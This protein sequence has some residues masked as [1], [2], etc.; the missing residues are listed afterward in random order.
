MTAEL[1]SRGADPLKA[2]EECDADLSLLHKVVAMKGDSD[3]IW[4]MKQLLQRGTF[5]DKQD[6]MN[7]KT[8]LMTCCADG[9]TNHEAMVI[10]L[11]HGADVSLVYD[12]VCHSQ[13]SSLVQ[14][15]TMCS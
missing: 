7:G 8:P 9:H 5:I 3:C 12:E 13:N 15:L 11:E 6:Y 1:M 14:F 10:L 4:L 2:Q